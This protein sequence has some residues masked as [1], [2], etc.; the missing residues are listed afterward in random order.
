MSAESSQFFIWRS[1]YI[2]SFLAQSRLPHTQIREDRSTH[3][4][5]RQQYSHALPNEFLSLPQHQQAAKNIPGSTGCDGKHCDNSSVAAGSMAATASSPLAFTSSRS[6]HSRQQN[7]DRGFRSS[8]SVIGCEASYMHHGTNF[9]DIKEET[10]AASSAA[11]Q[12]DEP[13]GQPQPSR[14]E[15]HSCPSS[16][17]ETD[18]SSGFSTLRRRSVTVT[19]KVSSK[20]R[21][22]SE[23]SLGL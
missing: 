11:Q 8:S 19:E 23:T 3:F 22:C 5:F 9:D 21:P 7:R 6:K 20:E 10:T 12:A 14:L 4:V 16:P 2:G 17:T 15:T 13:Q 1:R 18:C